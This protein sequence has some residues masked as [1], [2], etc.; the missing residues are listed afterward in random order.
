MINELAANRAAPLWGF[1][2]ASEPAPIDRVRSQLCPSL[3]SLYMINCH[4]DNIASKVIPPDL[5]KFTGKF[6]QLERCRNS[7]GS[8]L[9]LDTPK[10]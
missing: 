7:L 2:T 1:K 8:G 10:L 9:C 3:G 5:T 6:V 4:H